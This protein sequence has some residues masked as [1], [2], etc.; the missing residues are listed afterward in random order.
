M[1]S[2]PEF[3]F[4]SLILDDDFRGPVRDRRQL[5]V[6]TVREE[7]SGLDRRVSLAMSNER[8]V[9]CGRQKMKYSKF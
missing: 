3:A 1:S 5:N 4:A 2:S 6:I 7:Q 9:K 8:V